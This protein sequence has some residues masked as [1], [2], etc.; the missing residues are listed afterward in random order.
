MFPSG[1]FVWLCYQYSCDR[2][3]FFP[4]TA[5]TFQSCYSAFDSIRLINRNSDNTAHTHTHIHVYTKPTVTAIQLT[6]YSRGNTWHVLM[7]C[8]TDASAITLE[9]WDFQTSSTSSPWRQ[10]LSAQDWPSSPAPVMLVLSSLLSGSL[11]FEYRLCLENKQIIIFLFR[12]L[13][14]E[15]R[16]YLEDIPLIMCFC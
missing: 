4:S 9:T 8:C 10:R 15:Y 12:S 5:V 2:S 16:L 11:G 1:G 7:A 3:I 14:L 6:L 13:G